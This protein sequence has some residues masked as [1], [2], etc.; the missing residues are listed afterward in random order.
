MEEAFAF[1]NTYRNDI[2]KVSWTHQPTGERVRIVRYPDDAVGFV[3][4]YE[5]MPDWSEKE[6]RR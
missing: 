1:A 4:R 5:P 3:W 6:N 2:W